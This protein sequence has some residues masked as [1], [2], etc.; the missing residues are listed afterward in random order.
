MPW[1][2]HKIY[3]NFSE[4]GNIWINHKFLKFK[5]LGLRIKIWSSNLLWFG[6]NHTIHT[7][8]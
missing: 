7:R 4:L 2:N 5:I 1:A 6:E 8:L 3:I